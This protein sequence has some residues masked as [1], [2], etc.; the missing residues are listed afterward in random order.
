MSGSIFANLNGWPPGGEP[1]SAQ[2][3]YNPSQTLCETC[4]F[5]FGGAVNINVPGLMNIVTN[6]NDPV[7][8]LSLVDNLDGTTTITL[9]LGLAHSA[10]NSSVFGYT[11]TGPLITPVAGTPSVSFEF[12]L[13]DADVPALPG[14]LPDLTTSQAEVFIGTQVFLG[15]H[16]DFQGAAASFAA[17]PEPSFLWPVLVIAT[18]AAVI[19]YARLKL[20]LRRSLTARIPSA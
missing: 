10:S 4:S 11:A 17:V 18:L 2:L 12:T 20:P 9:S 5:D 3:I 16:I 8:E 6:A 1:F 7:G 13:P 19:R 14:P 15:P